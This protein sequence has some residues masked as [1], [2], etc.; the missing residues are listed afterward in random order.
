MAIELIAINSVYVNGYK[1]RDTILFCSI[2][3]LDLI[4]ASQAHLRWTQIC[5]K[6]GF[7]STFQLKN[8]S[9]DFKSDRR[10][11]VLGDFQSRWI[12]A[13]MNN[14]PNP[15]LRNQ[16]TISNYTYFAIS[17]ILLDPEAY[18][19]YFLYFFYSLNFIRFLFLFDSFY[20]FLLVS[21][22]AHSINS[23]AIPLYWNVLYYAQ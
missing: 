9:K 1:L 5:T 23:Y 12:Y 19:R 21:L 16:S 17:L 10:Q 11:W 13:Y 2:S 18:D 7:I 8:W 4:S 6:I 20:I 3:F 14:F 15:I 22:Y